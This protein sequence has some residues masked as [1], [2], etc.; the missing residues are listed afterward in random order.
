MDKEFLKQQINNHI[1]I[2]KYLS[3]YIL[4]LPGGII[5]LMLGDFSYIKI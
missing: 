5:T 3:T 4:V 1:E 2:R